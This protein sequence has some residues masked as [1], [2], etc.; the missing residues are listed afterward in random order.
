MPPETQYGF[1]LQRAD[2]QKNVDGRSADLFFLSNEFISVAL[3]NYGAR[4]VGLIVK[5]KEGQLV[6]V[7]LGFDTIQHYLDT[8]EVYHGAII[9][10]YANRIALG[11][12]TLDKKEYQLPVNNGKNHLHGGPGGFHNVVWEAEERSN[13]FIRFSYTSPDGEEGYPGQLEVNV[14]YKL[15]GSSLQILFEARTDTITVINLTNHAYFNLNGSGSIEKHKLQINADQITPIDENYIPTGLYAP[16]ASTPFDFRT[17]AEIGS[18]I[19]ADDVQLRNGG[20]YDHNFVLNKGTD[21]LSLAAVATGDRSGITLEIYTTEPGV[22]LYTGN[23]MRGENLL[24]GNFKDEYRTGFC[25][26]TQHFPDS[27]NQPTFPSVVLQPGQKYSSESRFEFS[28][29]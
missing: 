9:G 3:T 22:Q 8:K 4:I 14:T 29:T 16:V 15:G 20:G 19:N 11:R 23:F 21:H 12:F 17:P 28:T 26:E 13:S 5:D 10:R 24:K 1:V 18:R 25:L 6:D 27:P 7:I 2:F